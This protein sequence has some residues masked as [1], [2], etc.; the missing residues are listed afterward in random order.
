[1]KWFNGLFD[2][3]TSPANENLTAENSSPYA[4]ESSNGLTGQEAKLSIA[5]LKKF[6]PLRNLDDEIV[7]NLSHSVMH[8]AKNTIIFE[9]SQTSDHI[10][11]LLT[12]RIVMQPDSVNSYE[13]VAGS[14]LASL[15]LNCGTHY[16]ATAT[17]LTNKVNILKVSDS[18]SRIWANQCQEE[19][20]CV[21]L[22]DIELPAELSD[23]RFFNSFAQAYQ[24]NT[25]HLPSLPNVAL[26]LKQAMQQEIGIPEAVEI[27]QIDPPI[28]TKLIQVANSPI[29][30]A[31]TPINNCHDAIT[32]IGLNATR[33][34]VLGISLKQLFNTKDRM[35]M[36][37]MQKLWRN[38]LYLSSLCFVLAEEFSNINPEDALLAGLICDIGAIP[39]L[40]FAEQFPEQY[41]NLAELEASLPFFN[42]PVGSLVLHTLG[43]SA[44]LS[45]IP[46]QAEN[47]F[48]DS[49]EQLTITDIV[50]LAKLHSYFGS[51]KAKGL[52]YINTIPAYSKI[53]QGK[54]DA[55]FS[56]TILHKAQNRIQAILQLLT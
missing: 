11:Y 43:F 1:M 15:P 46:Y 17:A 40:H 9:R 27:I 50:I 23:N 35:L 10:Y 55:D 24:N 38:S 56:F 18:I 21:E 3:K 45:N 16:G 44:E 13:V 49:G 53:P 4:F 36:Q 28:V 54:L 2:S 52:P 5:Q 41:P 22:L 30:A 19:L 48:Y 51:K 29:Y 31:T 33:N 26:K 8:Y 14:T 42:G 12:G 37:G 47:W 6:V 32:R 39:L 7:A 34:L 25:L 20:S